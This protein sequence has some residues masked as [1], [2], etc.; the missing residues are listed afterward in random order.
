[1]LSLPLS[2]LERSYDTSTRLRACLCHF[3]AGDNIL[4]STTRK[5]G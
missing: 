3:G 4:I 5:G 1:M 2:A